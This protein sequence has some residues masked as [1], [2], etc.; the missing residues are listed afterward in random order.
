L[1]LFIVPFIDFKNCTIKD[2]HSRLDKYRIIHT[3]A[4]SSPAI[5]YF[6]FYAAF[7]AFTPPKCLNSLCQTLIPTIIFAATLPQ[8]NE[9]NINI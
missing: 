5:Y 8:S 2:D 7:V 4:K 3:S 6:L 1:F 9:Q